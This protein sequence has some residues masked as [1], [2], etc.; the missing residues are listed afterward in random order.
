MKKEKNLEYV[1]SAK[2]EFNHMTFK[3]FYNQEI[4]HKLRQELKLKNVMEVPKIVKIV[5]NVGAGEAV[6][7]KT[8][9]EKI[10]E[11][12]GLI[13][14]QKAIITKARK[15]IS[16]FKIRKGL[17]IG[18]KVTLRDKKMFSFLEKFVKVVVP[19]FRDFRGIRES[20]ID[21][22]GNLN[23]GVNEQTIF[24]EIDFD[25]IDKIRGLEITIVT[26]AKTK[27]KGKK[28]FELLGIPFK[29]S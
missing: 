3:D 27:E 21:Q 11:Q 25:K 13:T 10:Q 29:K 6:S 24:P 19:R 18:V 23:L 22:H 12:I 16:A 1:K 28:L 14:G 20:S 26:N 4:K 8:V 7:N 15:S 9:L 2:A 5:V 17:P